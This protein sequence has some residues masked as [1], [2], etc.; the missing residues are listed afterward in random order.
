MWPSWNEIAE[1]YLSVVVLVEMER[2]PH[3]VLHVE[4]P[5]GGQSVQCG[6]DVRIHWTT[7]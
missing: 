4:C 7:S 6:G 5:D 3:F 2:V 1:A